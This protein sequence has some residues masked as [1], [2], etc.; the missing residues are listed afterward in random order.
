[1]P[2]EPEPQVGMMLV[3]G[4]PDGRQIPVRIAEVKND[5]IIVIAKS[6]ANEVNKMT[7]QEYR[8]YKSKVN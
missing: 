7:W 8:K 4:T 5:G 3:M 1:M 6:T 2:K